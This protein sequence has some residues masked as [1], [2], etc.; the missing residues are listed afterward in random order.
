MVGKETMNKEHTPLEVVEAAGNYKFKY[1]EINDEDYGIDAVTNSNGF[2]IFSTP[3]L[4]NNTF[5]DLAYPSHTA[6][7]FTSAPY[8]VPIKDS[9][10]GV[11]SLS[12]LYPV[13]LI[14][15]L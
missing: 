4:S 7:P 2:K 1:P 9:F 5:I 3:I 12:N 15:S 13:L 14:I 6:C 8:G 10:P 11:Q